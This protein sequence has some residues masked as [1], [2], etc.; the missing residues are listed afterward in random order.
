ME[1]GGEK[2]MNPEEESSTFPALDGVQLFERWWRPKREPKAGIVLLHGLADHSG[3]YQE[4]ALHLTENEY[5]VDTFDLR[6]HGKSDG[7]RS[8]VGRFEEYLNDLDLFLDRVR[9][10]LPGLPLFLMGHSMGGVI[11]T[12]YALEQK[13][14]IRGVVLS[15]PAVHLSNEAPPPLLKVAS[16]ISRVMPRLHAVKINQEYISR[17]PAEVQAYD[18]D[19]L[20]YRKGVLMR[21]GSELVRA[22]RY[23]RE[24]MDAFSYPVLVLQGGGDRITKP[25]GSRRLSEKAA[26]TDTT[27]KL[28]EDLYHEI[29]NEPEKQQVFRDIVDWLDSHVRSGDR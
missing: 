13:P 19:P 25:E 17:D 12:F 6:G 20:I 16:L 11:V 9:A 7:L 14:R 3:R 8:Y 18:S 22:G 5:A 28:Y 23:V 21:T 15:A 27:F 10:R 26:S 29:L 4:I 24:R 2:A 1:P